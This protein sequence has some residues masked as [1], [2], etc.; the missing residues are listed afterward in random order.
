MRRRQSMPAGLMATG[1]RAGPFDQENGQRWHRD[2][3]AHWVHTDDG[4]TVGQQDFVGGRLGRRRS[5]AAAQ[6]G[7]VFDRDFALVA[8]A[9]GRDLGGCDFLGCRGQASLARC[10]DPLAR[11]DGSSLAPHPRHRTAL[12]SKGDR[13]FLYTAHIDIPPDLGRPVV[14]DGLEVKSTARCIVYIYRDGTRRRQEVVTQKIDVPELGADVRDANL[15][16][17]HSC[18]IGEFDPPIERKGGRPGG[19]L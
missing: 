19:G 15:Y 1:D 7:S 4:G 3:L 14:E 12:L 9:V 13:V 8:R 6:L 2:C 18:V 10:G 16:D 5:A 11:D 17:G